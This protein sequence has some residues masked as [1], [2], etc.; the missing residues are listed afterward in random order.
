VEPTASLL[1][2][3]A[4][5]LGALLGGLLAMPLARSRERAAR[6]TLEERLRGR[7]AE[8]VRVAAALQ[9]A[10]R[11]G[12]RLR[13]E[14]EALQLQ[15]AQL[16]AEATAERRVAAEKLAQLHDAEAQLGDAFRALSAE[17]LH[18][19]NAS[20]L[21]LARETLERFQD[22]ARGDLERRR[23]AID[24]LVRPL[25]EA[26]GQVDRKLGELERDR[27]AAFGTLGENLRGLAA[28]QAELARETSRLAGALRSPTVRGRWGEVQLRRVVEM[29]GMSAWCDF[30]TQVTATAEDGMLR[31]D[32]VVRLPNRRQVVVDAKAP[33]AAYLESLDAVDEEARRGRLR[34]HARQVRTHLGKLAAKSYWSQFE[35]APEFVVLFLPGEVFFSAALEQDPGLLEAGADRRVLLATPTTLI[36][37]LRA[38]AYGWRE[39][40]AAANARAIASLGKSLHE[41]LRTLAGHVTALRRGLEQAVEAFNRTVGSLEGR[42]L[43]AARRFQELGAA[44]GEEI[45]ELTTLDRRPRAV[46]ETSEEG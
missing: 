37:L 17:A 32:L 36:A 5:G 10:E 27:A 41:R 31:P 18:R 38:V 46:D 14:R 35:P 11:T 21:D 12:E 29:A 1:L 26:L 30:A 20:F 43:P 16:E 25:Q 45:E 15:L 34:E 33:F 2:I 39:E 3:A 7:E 24:E 44:G 13:A 22:G 9:A 4:L 6:A 42:V 28:G 23:Q 40:Q 19:N 8:L